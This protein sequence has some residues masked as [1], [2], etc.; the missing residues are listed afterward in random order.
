MFIFD[1]GLKKSMLFLS[2]TFE[3]L[4]FNHQALKTCTTTQPRRFQSFP[5]QPTAS[6][7]NIGHSKTS[8]QQHA[9]H[10]YHP[11]ESDVVSTFR[12]TSTQ[13]SPKPAPPVRQVF[14]PSVP[15]QQQQQQQRDAYIPP[16]S[17]VRH[18]FPGEPLPVTETNGSRYTNGY[19]DW[20]DQSPNPK[21]KSV[22]WCAESGERPSLTSSFIL[23]RSYSF[24]YL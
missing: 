18:Y 4:F 7:A 19:D 23:R 15:L 3:L 6:L 9:G 5:Q 20:D 22:R 1:A 14:H 21:M 24:K 10:T 11:R 2:V 8:F 16:G 17:H 13:R 12:S